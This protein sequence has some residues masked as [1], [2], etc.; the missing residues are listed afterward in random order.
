MSESSSEYFTI[1]FLKD[2]KTKGRGANRKILVYVKWENYSAS[3]NT[4]EPL[5]NLTL[6]CAIDLLEELRLVIIDAKKIKLVQ[7][8]LEFMKKEQEE[9]EEEIKKESQEEI[10]TDINNNPGTSIDRKSKSLENKPKSSTIP[11]IFDNMRSIHVET[12]CLGNRTANNNTKSPAINL[13]MGQ[14]QSSSKT[15]VNKNLNNATN[16]IKLPLYKPE[17]HQKSSKG[18]LQDK[19]KKKLHDILYQDIMIGD[20]NIKVV[21]ATL[22]AEKE[23]LSKKIILLKSEIE[24]TQNPKELMQLMFDKLLSAD[25]IIKSFQSKIKQHNAK[26][27]A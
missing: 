24:I 14:R 23:I 3:Y 8:A 2:I 22:N 18:K 6:P 15:N 17:S 27:R 4:W 10:A 5:N 11:E 7:E 9:E 26:F 25:A 13:K 12:N 1:E 20:D 21:K 16:Y 19:S